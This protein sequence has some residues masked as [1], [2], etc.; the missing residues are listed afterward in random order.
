MGTKS[1]TLSDLNQI[2]VSVKMTS[3]LKQLLEN[4][5]FS[6]GKT[7]SQLIRDWVKSLENKTA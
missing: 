4:A 1:K 2:N 3:E 7:K 5:S 6:A